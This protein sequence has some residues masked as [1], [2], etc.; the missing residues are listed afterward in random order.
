[1]SDI[2]DEVEKFR[3]TVTAGDVS[4]L[5]QAIA[6]AIEL[7]ESLDS[8]RQTL[9]MMMDEIKASE[10]ENHKELMKREIQRTVDD[11]RLI[12]KAEEA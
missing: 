10:I 1:M 12:A 7:I 4:E 6:E 3:G 9:W 2:K 8:E 5:K 11:I